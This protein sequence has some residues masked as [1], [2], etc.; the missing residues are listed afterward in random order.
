AGTGHE[1][2]TVRAAF[3]RRH[4]DAPLSDLRGAE[5]T[6]PAVRRQA[7]GH[8]YLHLATHGF[9]A[10]PHALSALSGRLG[11][12]DPLGRDHFRPAAGWHP[13]LLSGIV[14]A[15][16]NRRGD[17]ILTAL[18]LGRL[19][20][21]KEER[22]GRRAGETGNGEGAGGEGALGLQRAFVSAGARATVG[23]LWSV[24]DAA[25]S[26]LMEQFY[27]RLWGKQELSKLEAL[28][29]AQLFVL[30]N[31]GKVIARARELRA[32]LIK[33][34]IGEA[35]LAARGLGKQALAL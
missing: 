15:G 19:S 13:G 26:V 29:Q 11:N 28:R 7:G 24:S 23:S 6:V 30:N 20:L 31:P 16:A 17:G 27:Q 4:W 10:P 9:F 8:R 33:R 12:L 21:E 5:G 22:A 35:E 14:L 18:E 1:A 3:R 25:T 34:G 2:D 32:E